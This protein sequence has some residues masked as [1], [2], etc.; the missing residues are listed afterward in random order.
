[1]TPAP[2]MPSG[3]APA[4][5]RDASGQVAG[6]A[7]DAA[8]A[9]AAGFAAQVQAWSLALGAAPAAAAVAGAA[10]RAVSRASSAGHVCWP[11]AD[12][13]LD[14]PLLLASHV[15]GTP[16]APGTCPLVLDLGDDADAGEA[17]AFDPARQTSGAGHDDPAKARPPALQ[18]GRLYLHRDFDHEQALARRLVQAARAAPLPLPP[19]LQGLMRA[20]FVP[21][22]AGRGKDPDDGSINALAEGG[23]NVQTAGRTDGPAEGRID[24]QAEGPISGQQL[25]AALALRQRLLVVSGGPGTGK[26]TTVVQLLALLLAAQPGSRIALAAPTGK[27]AARMAEALQARAA[28]LPAILPE[29]VRQGLPTQAS[30]VHRLL[31]ATN[32]AGRFRH[33]A[34]NPLPIDVLVVDEASML[35]LALAR[36]L[37]DAVPQAARIVLLGDK[38]QLAAVESG[39]VFSDLSASPALSPATREALVALCGVAPAALQAPASTASTALPDS[40]VWLTQN[41]R[42]AADSA[43]GQLASAVRAGDVAV[44]QA[45]LQAGGDALSLAAPGPA[46]VAQAQAGYAAYASALL[47]PG[48]GPAQAHAA[49]ARFRVL[50]ALR[51]G[52]LGVDGL[53]AQ[54]ARWLRENLAALQPPGADPLSPWFA[55]RPVAVLRNDPGLGLFNGDVGIALPASG[56]AGEA[57]EAHAATANTAPAPVAGAPAG[58]DL[59]VW[60]ADARQPGG[61]RAVAP[62]RLPAHDTALAMTVH[63]SQGSEFDA[64]L[65]VLPGPGSRVL[66]RELLYT[67]VTRARHQVALAASPAAVAA[68]VA[69]PTR[70]HSGLLARLREAAAEPPT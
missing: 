49:L 50:C 6:T 14:A 2:E 48:A 12:T 38:D 57:G 65:V 4:A 16:A 68:A 54:L 32:E 63:Q 22:P 28:A 62:A 10:A 11:L 56:A 7:F 9:L 34:G 3:P 69:T 67:A 64:V 41:H 47:Q 61:Y 39:A 23:M 15:V 60:F 53:N 59:L 51:G 17:G 27:A 35:D 36:R 70:R 37:L 45:L 24:G 1:M 29:G 42:F 31:G 18:P 40:V 66:T 44:A 8:E 55:G 52:A 25:A 20:L 33:H 43:I 21:A 13:G 58:Q 19:G 5:A 26:T 46:T 30:T